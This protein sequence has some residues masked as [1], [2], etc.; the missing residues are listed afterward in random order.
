M[1]QQTDYKSIVLDEKNRPVVEG[2][3]IKVRELVKDYLAYGWSPEEM[4]W[5][6]PSLTMAQVHAALAYYY[7]HKQELDE[8]IQRNF[9]HYQQL[10]AENMD[11]PVRR[12]LRGLNVL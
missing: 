7:D 3:S 1:S 10:R 2:T 4:Q 11:S 9:E 12:K 8:E 6:H 5:Q